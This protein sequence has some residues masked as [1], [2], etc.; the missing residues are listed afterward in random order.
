MTRPMRSGRVPFGPIALAMALAAGVVTAG[1]QDYPSRPVR[2]ISPVPPGGLSDVALRP[3]AQALSKSLGQ[4][5][6]VDNRAGAGGTLAGRAC[7]QAAPDGYT[8]CNFFN[9][10]IS[11]APFL[12]KNPGYDPYRDF[13][14]ITNGYFIT[15]AFLVTPSLNVNTL[16]ELIALSKSRPHGLDYASPSTGATMFIENFNQ[17]TGAKFR[18]IPYKSGT[19]VANA[20]LTNTVQV[21]VVGVGTLVPHLQAGTFK[22]LSVDSA[23]RLALLPNVPTLKELGYEATRIKTWYGFV[24]PA[25][26]PPAV[27]GK[28]HAHIVQ[29][30]GDPEIRQRAFINA[31]LE[32][33]TNTPEEFARFLQEDRE[34]TAAQAKRAG[35]RPE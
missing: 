10:V 33:A 28:L 17:H 8:F 18:T 30:Y 35:I 23:Q 5:M 22:A 20:L 4:P 11:N 12:F 13:T 29:A 27:I 14:P 7:A 9:D 25:G 1:A 15:T 34:R 24:A 21:A 16:E 6:I 26:T 32:P 3:V 31:G 2:I 19:E